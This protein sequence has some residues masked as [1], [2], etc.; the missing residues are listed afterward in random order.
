MPGRLSVSRTFGDIE[1]KE[2]CFGG[3]PGVIVA[4]PEIKTFRVQNDHD[5][6]VM[7][8][9]GIFDKLTNKE[10]IDLVWVNGKK[11]VKEENL[12]NSCKTF[13]VDIHSLCANSVELIL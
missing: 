2:V 5:F 7:G 3:K 10:I 6:I 9:D 1:A 8:C 11:R 12:S 13:D 4:E